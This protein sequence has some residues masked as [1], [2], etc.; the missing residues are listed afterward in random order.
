MTKLEDDY[1][2]KLS[3]Q[4]L[5]QSIE[6]SRIGDHPSV[7]YLYKNIPE[8]SI[9]YAITKNRSCHNVLNLALYQSF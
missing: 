2:E 8:R 9:F 6:Q 3:T 5:E 1:Y 4:V 7:T